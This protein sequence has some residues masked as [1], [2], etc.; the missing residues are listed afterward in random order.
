MD[1]WMDQGEQ[2]SFKNVNIIIYRNNSP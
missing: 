1:G 2:R